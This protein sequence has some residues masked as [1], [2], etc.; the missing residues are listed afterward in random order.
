MPRANPLRRFRHA[1]ANGVPLSD[2]TRARLVARTRGYALVEAAGA[3]D[4]ATS[5]R[6]TDVLSGAAR[7]S[8]VLIV[9]LSRVTLLAAAGFH[10]LERTA[11]LMAGRGGSLHLACADGSPAARVLR[12]LDEGNRWPVHPDVPTAVA[13]VG[14]HP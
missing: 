1:A 13:S 6:L 11:T 8:P 10:C 14:E 7:G 3:L 2:G 9:D 5:S 4:I 12:L